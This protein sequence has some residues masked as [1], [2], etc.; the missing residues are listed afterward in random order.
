MRDSATFA[1]RTSLELVQRALVEDDEDARWQIV[2]EL[3]RRGGK[4]ELEL[5]RGLLEGGE[6]EQVLA[7]DILGQ[8]GFAQR[9]L[10]V[11]PLGPDAAQLIGRALTSSSPAVQQAAA[12]AAGHLKW[13]TLFERVIALAGSDDSEVRQAVAFALSG[14]EDDASVHALIRLSEDADDDVRNWATFGLGTQSDRR[15]ELV[16]DALARRIDDA[17]DETRGEAWSGLAVKSDARAFEPVLRSLESDELWLLAIEAAETYRHPAFL[18]ALDR[19][20]ATC[21]DPADGHFRRRLEV[22]IRACRAGAIDV[23]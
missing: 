8:L 23:T 1:E 18:P 22:A 21:Q 13:E 15:D 19:W 12:S 4:G 7:C 14:R 9:E 17:H 2:N 16:C 10:G 3:H 20:L 11:A 6:P 5:A